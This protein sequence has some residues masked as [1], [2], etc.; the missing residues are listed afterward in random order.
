M[1]RFNPGQEKHLA[2]ILKYLTTEQRTD[3]YN[4]IKDKLPNILKTDYNLLG[5]PAL[6]YLTPEQQASIVDMKQLIDLEQ[7][8]E[9]MDLYKAS[10]TE[11]RSDEKDGSQ[12]DG[13]DNTIN[14]TS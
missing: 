2:S 10:M 6:G 12:L 4:A 1:I 5:S 8:K 14:K 13:Q 11:L 9:T 3:I 7:Q